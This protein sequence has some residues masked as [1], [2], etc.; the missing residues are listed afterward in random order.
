MRQTRRFLIIFMAWMFINAGSVYAQVENGAVITS[1]TSGEAVQGLVPILGSTDLP[2]FV[3][4]EVAFGYAGETTSTWFLISTI[5][6]PVLSGLLATWDTTSITDGNYVVRLRVH[7]NDGSMRELT[8]PNLRVRNYTLV[9]TPTPEP[10]AVKP[11]LLPTLTL[12]PTQFPTPTLLPT[13]QAVLTPTDVTMSIGI[14]GLG[15]IVLFS[16]LGIYLWLRR[17]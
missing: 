6:H 3:T 12:T 7:L 13:N 11:T 8:V 16:I 5:D 10:T 15:A 17:K 9:E 14:G 2:G 4:S 1:P